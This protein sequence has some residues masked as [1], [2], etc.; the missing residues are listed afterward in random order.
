MDRQTRKVL[1]DGS[2]AGLQLAF[3]IVI[4]LGIGY[5]LDGKLGTMP[6]LTFIGFFLGVFAGF[7]DLFR[8]VKRMNEPEEEDDGD[9]G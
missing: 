1:I 8:M 5:F 3:T 6:W 7:R 9:E 4:G 2:M